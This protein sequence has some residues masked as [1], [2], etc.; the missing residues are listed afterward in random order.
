[1]TFANIVDAA[2]ADDLGF[3]VVER[4]ILDSR[5]VDLGV[6]HVYIPTVAGIRRL[7][8]KTLGK[9]RATH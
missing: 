1:M 8:N 6:F 7:Y 5:R 3:W 2:L 9:S 4:E